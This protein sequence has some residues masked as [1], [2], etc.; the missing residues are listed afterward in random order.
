[1]HHA[2][3]RYVGLSA[4]GSTVSALRAYFNWGKA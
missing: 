4:R 1:M 2:L 3:E